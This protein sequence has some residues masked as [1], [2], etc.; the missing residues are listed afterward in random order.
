MEKELKGRVALVTGGSRG[1]GRGI[2][3]KLAELGAI[4]IV[5]YS[6]REDAAQEV[7][8]EIESH[9]GQA[10]FLGFNVNDSSAVDSA[11]KKILEQEK[12]L[13]ILINNAGI[14]IDSL[15]MRMSDEDWGR[16][17]EVNLTGAFYCARAAM[18]YMMKA[19]S[20]KILILVR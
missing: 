11:M 7:V 10:W 12:K 4:V 2:S 20:G 8:R 6:S 15:A 17:L 18:K 13:D 1:I 5:N 9:G 16:V 14:S 3:L 19:R